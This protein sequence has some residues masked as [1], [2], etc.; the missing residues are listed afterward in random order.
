M[1]WGLTRFQ[2]TG[3]THFVTFCCYHRRH[4][5]TGDASCRVFES[6]LERV[7]RSYRLYIYAYVVMP[8][9]V[10]LLLSEPQT[11]NAQTQSG[12]TQARVWLE[13]ESRLAP[14]VRTLHTGRRIEVVEARRVAPFNRRCGTL[15]AKTVLGLQCTKLSPVCAE[16]ALYSQQSGEARIVRPSPGLAV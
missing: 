14:D 8:E 11:Q 16:A 1:P 13:W 12:P 3:Q 2:Q 15:L 7:R 9:H 4:L 5:L 6:A 10:H